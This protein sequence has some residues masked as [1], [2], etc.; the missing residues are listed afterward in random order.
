LNTESELEAA[1]VAALHADDVT[2]LGAHLVPPGADAEEYVDEVVGSM[3][4][5]VAPHVDRIDVFWEP[6]SADEGRSRRVVEAGERA[7][8][9]RGVHGNQ[10]GDGTGVQVAGELGAASV[11]DVKYLTDED[12]G[13]LAG[14]GAVATML[15]ACDLSTR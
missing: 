10:R 3:L 1:Q 9:G 8:L 13:A 14:A 7:G 2:F 15:P 6:G 5:Q 4:E 12:V 11:D